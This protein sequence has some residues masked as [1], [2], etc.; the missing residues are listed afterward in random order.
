MRFSAQSDEPGQNIRTVL[1][2]FFTVKNYFDDDDDDN[3]GD[4]DEHKD[5]VGDDENDNDDDYAVDDRS[6]IPHDR[7]LAI[8][9]G[10]S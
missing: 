8:V 6:Y 4:D 2:Y 10:S 9:V 3:N 7:C 5:G 1:H